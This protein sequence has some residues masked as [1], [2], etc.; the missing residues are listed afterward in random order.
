MKDNIADSLT[1][2]PGEW[3][4]V[5]DGGPPPFDDTPWIPSCEVLLAAREVWDAHGQW[6]PLGAFAVSIRSNVL[7][8]VALKTPR[9]D[10]ASPDYT[11]GECFECGRGAAFVS[12]AFFTRV[13]EDCAAFYDF[14]DRDPKLISFSG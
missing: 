4:V 2:H 3:V 11:Y 13:C 9:T 6:S 14:I 7:Y 12:A 8:A 10:V 5:F 1:S